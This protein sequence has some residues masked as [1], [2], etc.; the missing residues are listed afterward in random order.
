MALKAVSW[1]FLP[2][3]P[4]GF[5]KSENEE[6]ANWEMPAENSFFWAFLQI[7]KEQM[8]KIK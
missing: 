8:N 3:L 7:Q 4:T 1:F 6:E 5:M 2:C